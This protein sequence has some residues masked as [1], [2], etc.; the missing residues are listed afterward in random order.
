MINTDL[1][2][3]DIK[4]E[5]DPITYIQVDLFKDE[6]IELNSSVQNVNDI[7]KTFS[8]FSQSFT[9]PAT[10][11]NNG[12]FEHYYNTDI[13]GTF[14][15]NIRIRG[16]I[17]CGSLPFKY[18]VIQLEDVKLKDM[19]PDSYTVRFFSA[20]VNLSDRFGDDDLTTLTSLS[21]FDH[22]YN[23]SIFD[24]TYS[25]SL[26]EDLYYPLVTSARPYQIGTGDANDIT[27]VS[28]QLQFTELRPALKLI[29][30]IEAIET[31]YNFTFDRDF[32]G[33]AVFG[34]LHMW[35]FNNLEVSRNIEQLK[36]DF[37]SKDSGTEIFGGVPFGYITTVAGIGFNELDL[38]TDTLIWSND[39]IPTLY[40]PPV[41]YV[42]GQ[43]WS[44]ILRTL[45][46]QIT[47][48]STNSYNIYVYKNGQPFLT[49]LD[50]LG[51]KNINIITTF[52]NLPNDEY[53]FFITS[54]LGITF[55]TTL[56]RATRLTVR[57]T[58]GGFATYFE[59]QRVEGYS[60]SQTIIPIFPV[61]QNL[62]KIKVRD[63]ITSLIKMFNLALVPL[64]ANGFK[65][66]PLDDWYS[67]GNL[68]DITKY[69]DSKDVNFKRPKLFKNILFQHQKSG[70]IF[71]EEFRNNQGGIL[72][73]GDLQ[74]IYQI[75]G[76]ELKVQTEVENLMFNRL[77][78]E[79]TGDVTN[80]QVGLSLDKNTQPYLGKPYIFY[81]CGFQ[82]YDVPIKANGHTDID[83]TYL[84]ST[85]NDFI[86]EQV[87]NSVN[88]STDIST[89]LFSEIPRNLYSNF[90]SDYISDLYST[91]RRLSS[92]KANLPI[93][94]IIKLRLNDRIVI[95]G[96]AYI[97]NSMKTNLTTGDVDLELLNYI[98][99]PFTS[100]TSN[101][102]LT[103]D[104]I[105]YS[106]DSTILSA[107]MTYIYLADISP[108]PNGVEY[109]T[110]LVSYARQD[111][112]CKIS[113]NSP[114]L[115]TKVD[116][117]DGT[118]WIN[119]ENASGQTTNYLLIKVDESTTDRSMDLS[120]GMGGDTFTITINQQQL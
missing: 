116:T 48:L 66:L 103:A 25:N 84:T 40:D 27:N 114:Y 32:L 107:D 72:G 44:E 20:S 55:T 102:P 68:V 117:G 52:T 26:G 45:T 77:T 115:V 9:I 69:I 64:N 118:N 97:I 34:N 70:Q 58:S 3:Q 119:L 11:K 110:L 83:Y 12:V 88:Y 120:I 79:T 7:S 90:W 98:G 42:V 56:F 100:A 81:K 67:Q 35:L 53:T 57:Q 85:E 16:Y 23:A 82:N 54:L 4:Q 51:N 108:I 74:A 38:A 14:N 39:F 94:I 63:F 75:D 28:G 22:Q 41:W 95:D 29:R 109:E 43:G 101:I 2:I 89:F 112:D 19:Q 13:D 8:D 106:A 24:A 113:A 33:R 46:L 59:S 17:E 96:K 99:L 36:I 91:K 93:G 21:E 30:I 92:W 61:S 31:K 104:T 80:V 18:G 49:R 37:T 62:P 50:L 65:L 15:P 5:T 73:Y 78:D 71:N 86:L 111:F 87:S 76:A 1:Y 6:N 10:P 105:D 47:T 60:A